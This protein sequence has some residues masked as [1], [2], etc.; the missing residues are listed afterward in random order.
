M[1]PKITT[2]SKYS[3]DWI[4]RAYGR[5]SSFKLS[6]RPIFKLIDLPIIIAQ[7]QVQTFIDSDSTISVMSFQLFKQLKL[8]LKLINNSSV[9]VSQV[10]GI[11]QSIGRVTSNITIGKTTRFHA[12]SHFT[13]WITSDI[14]YLSV[15]ILENCS[16]S[17]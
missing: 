16:T 1:E 17:K 4:T 8:I 13:P 15:S 10:N 11:S 2:K 12:K 6:Q 9:T 3:C 7:K 14:R 5:D